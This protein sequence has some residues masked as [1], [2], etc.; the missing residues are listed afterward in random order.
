MSGLFGCC[1][2]LKPKYK[3][4][5]DNIFPADPQEGLV[6]N[7]LEKLLFFAMKSP[8]KLDRIGEYLAIRLSRDISHG[9]KE[10][11]IMS[12]EALDRLLITC[13]SHMLNVFVESFL[14]MVHKLLE[15]SDPKFVILATESFIKFSNVEEDVP[16]YHRS[17]DFFVEKFSAMCHDN[18]QNVELRDKVCVAGIEGLHGIIRKTSN[19]DLQINIWDPQFMDKIIP[20]LLYNMQKASNF[21]SLEPESPTSETHP[22][23]VAEK[24]FRD[25]ICRASFGNISS[26]IA[27][28][29]VHLDL[30]KLWEPNAFAIYCFKIVIYS[31]Q[32]QY[33]YIVVQKLLN[34]LDECIQYE[35]KIKTNVVDVLTQTVV[36]SAGGSIGP[37]VLD[38]FNT[39]LRHLR[40]SVECDTA[41]SEDTSEEKYFQE[42][43]IMTI[44]EF[45]NNLPDYQKIEILMFVMSKIP[46]IQFLDDYVTDTERSPKQ[47]ALQMNLLKTILKVATK[48]KT[49]TMSKAFP[50]SFLEPLMKMSLDIDPGIRHIIQ[51]ILHTLIDRHDNLQKCAKVV[52]LADVNDMEL[53]VDKP[54]R[55]DMLFMKKHG[56]VFYWYL[57]ENIKLLNNRVDNYEALYCT[58]CLISLEIA[59]DE[60][61]LEMVRF[62]LG[63]QQRCISSSQLPLTHKCS[64][65]ALVAAFF[66]ILS[67]LL[68]VPELSAHI[69]EVVETRRAECPY[70]LP[71]VAFNRTNTSASYPQSDIMKPEWLFN[72]EKMVTA[73][74]N[75]GHESV[76]LDTISVHAPTST[77]VVDLSRSTSDLHSISLDI[78]SGA[79]TPALRRGSRVGEEI[80]FEAL[81]KVLE[82]DTGRDREENERKRRIVESFKHGPFEDI[83]AR[84][85]EQSLQINDKLNKIFSLISAN[86]EEELDTP[87]NE[88]TG[89]NTVLDMKYPSLFVY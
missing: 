29:L 74:H 32:A 9:R 10:Y 85:E 89:V 54:L 60:V 50:I 2:K 14:K 41:S 76:N 7:N 39:L 86:S 38:V 33:G 70:Y 34:H 87:E 27:P 68:A 88:T 55:Q 63:M 73:L 44:G 47:L 1:S 78:P 67:H 81:K 30:H 57:M 83:V 23:A 15:T 25:L 69:N 13:H 16:N 75:S 51:Q 12:M 56:S 80:T 20:S 46:A 58:L 3:I 43:I 64:I 66:N 59:A 52:L 5:V 6:K 18:N 40:I 8:E 84:S 4:L 31:V 71:E 37:S 26:I 53:N 82:D 77:D 17:Y 65:Q 72:G 24:V 21:A 48:Y 42:A 49:D 45:A 61:L 11:A 79:S 36:V 19:D 35:A 28:V 22:S 62:A